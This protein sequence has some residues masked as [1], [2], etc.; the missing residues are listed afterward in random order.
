MLIGGIGAR[1][2]DSYFTPYANQSFLTLLQ[3]PSA[4]PENMQMSGVEIHANVVATLLDRA[5]IITPWWLCNPCC[6]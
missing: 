3:S 1:F 2:Q 6:W 4:Q 5:F